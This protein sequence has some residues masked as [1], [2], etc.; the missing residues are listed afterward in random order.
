MAKHSRRK[1]RQ[2]KLTNEQILGLSEL[3][4]KI[5][6]HYGAPQDIEWARENNRFYVLQSRPITTL[7]G[8]SKIEKVTQTDFFI[9]K[10]D[11]R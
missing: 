10:T 3:I 1:G 6:D 5:E 9:S 2:Q 8:T 11:H 4:I 7:G